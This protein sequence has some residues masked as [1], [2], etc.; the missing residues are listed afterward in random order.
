M[1]KGNQECCTGIEIW[2]LARVNASVAESINIEQRRDKNL[3]CQDLSGSCSGDRT[4][5]VFLPGVSCSLITEFLP[6]LF[7]SVIL[8][9]IRVSNIF[10]N[11]SALNS[12]YFAPVSLMGLAEQLC[13]YHRKAGITCFLQLAFYKLLG[14]LEI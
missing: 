2:P 10:P 9:L 14:L 12:S 4:L 6:L 5:P 1:R 7:V 11:G 8:S 13:C 3:H